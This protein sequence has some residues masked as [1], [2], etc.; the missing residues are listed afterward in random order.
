[1]AARRIYP[2]HPE[3]GYR[4]VGEVG[5]RGGEDATVGVVSYG[6]NVELTVLL[7]FGGTE[8]Q[9][10]HGGM[11]ALVCVHVIQVQV[12]P[13]TEFLVCPMTECACL[14]MKKA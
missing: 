11:S 6:V 3:R 14:W 1:M 12:Y 4:R 5:G 13:E 10:A 8:T 9:T 2:E 7:V